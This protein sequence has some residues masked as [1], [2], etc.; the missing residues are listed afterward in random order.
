MPVSRQ[1]APIV[2]V[3]LTAAS[4]GTR[5]WAARSMAVPWIA[6]DETIY[7]LLG[8]SLWEDGSHSILGTAA[9]SYSFVYPALIGLP[10][11]LAN[12]ETGVTVVQALGAVLMSATALL[13]YLWG[14]GP[15][16]EWW[17]VAAAGLTLAVP[18]LAY[19]GLVM[20]E[21]AVF[22]IAT[23]ALWAIASA[24]EWPSPARQALAAGA[25]VL[26][27]GTH[28]R[29]VALIPTLFVAVALQCGFLRSLE[30]ARRQ[31]V[32]LAGIASACAATLAGFAVSGRW[33]DIF[34]A[35]A[36]ATGGYELRAA[37]TDVLWHAA[38]VFVL[39]AGIPLVALAVMTV[40]CVARRVRDPSAC[41]LVATTLA[42]T[43]LLVLEVGTFASRWVGHL[44]LRDLQPV[45]PP[46]M[47]VFA[48]WIVRG[49]PRP[50]PWIHLAALAIAI[51]AVLLPVGRF[52]VQE[53][54]LDAF[55]LI[56]LWRLA[57]A[58]SL[59]TLE[60]VY[61]LSVSTLVVLAVFL[62]RRACVA[63]PV[64][65]ALALVS[66]SILSTRQIDRLTHLD[67]AWVFDTGDPRWIDRAADGPVTYLQAETAFSAGLWK[68]AFWNRRIDAVAYLP[69][70]A[71][72]PPLAPTVV[73]LQPNGLL[74]TRDGGG[75]QATLVVSPTEIELFGE[76]VAQAPRSTDTTGL[77]LWRAE[78]PVRVSSVR[79][80][81]QPDGDINGSAH[82]TV[83][84]CGLGSL[85][86]TLFGKAGGPVE[87]RADGIL[88]ARPLLAANTV[89]NGSVA[90]PPDA[91]GQSLCA[92]ELV[93][94]GLVGS[95][96]LEF[97]RD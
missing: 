45:V 76:S 53:S 47:L 67:R 97:V 83:Y 77:T 32:F 41:A 62:A 79:S 61:T 49:A 7:A 55:S 5:F 92:F 80:G 75:L 20:S 58:T 1:V 90:A 15:L 2:L 23:L 27:L 69:E 78:R 40:E 18:D 26:A 38:G 46:L 72:L 37:A 50:R 94:R 17:A 96:R 24:L 6:P 56:P 48:L 9:A 64:I 19:S 44:A 43:S 60:L 13:V 73:A 59:S 8:R 54:A 95:T 33:Q 51:P 16:G 71:R 12:L 74:R 81:V 86:L 21:V 66:L 10:L 22:P 84:A 68:Q 82:L 4:A 25:I 85:E 11:S 35:Y 52:A 31:A 36:A 93:S 34:G 70:A 29:L 91:D 14:R 28:V 30:P 88:R 39:V 57:E 65:V 42:W 89:W 3:L 87:I 63:L